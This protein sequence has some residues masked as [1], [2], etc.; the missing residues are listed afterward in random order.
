MQLIR[1]IDRGTGVLPKDGRRDPG[2]AE[3]AIQSSLPSFDV[4]LRLFNGSWSYDVKMTSQIKIVGMT[5]CE[6]LSIDIARRAAV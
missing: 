1:P 2:S 4:V 3:S 6:D 5:R